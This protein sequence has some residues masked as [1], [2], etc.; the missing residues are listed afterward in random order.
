MTPKDVIG[1]TAEEV[2]G[3]IVL[4]VEFYDYTMQRLNPSSVTINTYNEFTIASEDVRITYGTTQGSR[5]HA[6]T[7][8]TENS[9]KAIGDDHYTQDI[10][11][12]RPVQFI[13]LTTSNK[14]YTKFKFIQ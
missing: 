10:I 7:N 5:V 1:S 13:K 4:E 8:I 14:E 3:Q 6:K 12:L 11:S 2:Y 9:L